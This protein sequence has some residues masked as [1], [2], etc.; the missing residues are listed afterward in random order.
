MPMGMGLTN[1]YYMNPKPFWF[2]VVPCD[3][4]TN[5]IIV[6]SM[7]ASRFE[8]QLSIYHCSSSPSAQC[9]LNAYFRESAEYLKFNPYSSAISEN[10]G[11]NAV[12]TLAEW[13][14]D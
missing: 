9:E 12:R 10:V 14:R 11:F 6:T 5:A 7:V 13:E 2:T 8:P 1:T 4:C 3:L